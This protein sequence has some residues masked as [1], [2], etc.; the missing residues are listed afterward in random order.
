MPDQIADQPQERDQDEEH[1]RHVDEGH[2]PARGR[3]CM[4]GRALLRWEEPGGGATS[5][6]CCV[7][8]LSVHYSMNSNVK[9]P[10]R[11]STEWEW[12][13]EESIA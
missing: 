9:L 12:R 10:T 4:G 5:Q 8:A 11:F 7:Y 1:L 2:G 13:W 3:A 6:P